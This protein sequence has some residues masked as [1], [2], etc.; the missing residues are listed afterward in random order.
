MDSAVQAVPQAEFVRQILNQTILDNWPF[1]ILL[2]AAVFLTCS[3]GAF[4]VSY[5]TRRA[6]HYATKADIDEVLQLARDNTR[7]VKEV[8]SAISRADWNEKEYL[9]LRR[10]KMEQLITMVYDTSDWLAKV[11]QLCL[12]DAT[13]LPDSNLIGRTHMIGVLYFP[14]IHQILTDYIS[15]AH[16]F[17]IWLLKTKQDL[18]RASNAEEKRKVAEATLTEYG[19]QYR[20]LRTNEIAVERAGKEIMQQIITPKKSVAAA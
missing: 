19:V 6:K 17:H 13:E 12:S 8:E 9:T 2:L 7:A 16:S 15:A 4:L 20:T 11:R 1:W 14:E 10:Q 3:G 18:I 5:W